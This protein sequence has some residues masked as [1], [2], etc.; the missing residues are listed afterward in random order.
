MVAIG[1][2]NVWGHM[3]E[4]EEACVFYECMGEWGRVWREGSGSSWHV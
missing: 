3:R 2:H 1:L 4:S